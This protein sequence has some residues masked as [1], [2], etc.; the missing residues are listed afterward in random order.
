MS[1]TA[2]FIERVTFGVFQNSYGENAA[3]NFIIPLDA[4]HF[5]FFDI[6]P[7]PF[8]FTIFIVGKNNYHLVV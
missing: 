2:N 4:Q 6:F 7:S 5:F 3:F 1:N 8:V